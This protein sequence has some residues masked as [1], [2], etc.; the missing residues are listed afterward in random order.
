MLS[1]YDRDDLP[2]IQLAFL[3]GDGVE[4][5]RSERLGGAVAGWT[6]FLGHAGIPAGTR[7]VDLHL[8]GTRNGGVDNDSYF[9]DLEL[10]TAGDGALAACVSPPAYPHDDEPVDCDPPADD[11]DVSADDDDSVAEPDVGCSCGLSGT[12]D[13]PVAGLLLVWLLSRAT[14]RR[15]IRR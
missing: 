7:A 4:L 8:L 9:D 2:E 5:G 3:D 1:D 12:S 11:D 13:A 14:R 15:R 10:R 6:R